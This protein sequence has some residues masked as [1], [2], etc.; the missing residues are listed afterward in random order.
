MVKLFVFFCCVILSCSCTLTGSLLLGLFGVWQGI[1][2]VRYK[3]DM[4]DRLYPD[5]GID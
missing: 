2:I 3:F 4:I 5:G 1:R